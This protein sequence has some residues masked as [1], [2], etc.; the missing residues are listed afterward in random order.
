[1]SQGSRS[2]PSR[3]VMNRRSVAGVIV[4]VVIIALAALALLFFML[5]DLLVDR[6]WFE[7][8]HQLQVWDLN[9]FSRL[10]LWI[11]VSVVAFLVLTAS[12]WL[13]VRSAGEAAPH[14]T[15][16]RKS[17]RGTQTPEGFRPPPT[18]DV[19]VEVLT[20]IDEV[21]REI[22]PRVLGLVLTGVAL[23]LALLIGLSTSAEWQTL[24]LY[25]HQATEAAVGAA[26]AGP[27][28][29]TPVAALT[30]PIFGRPLTFYLFDMPFYRMAAELVGSILDSLILLTGLAY[31]VLARRSGSLPGGRLWAWHLGILVALRIAIGA[32]GFQLDKF[33]LVFSQR[34]YPLPSGVSATDA[35]VR[36]PAADVLTLLT[37]AAAI[38]VLAAIVRQRFTWALGVFGVWV[39]VAVA[40]GLLAVVNQSLF[41]NPNPLDQER[42]YISNDIKATRLAYGLDGW[43]SRPYPAINVLT[44]AAL[45]DDAET[46]ANARLWDYRPLGATLDQLQTVRQYYDFADVDIDRYPIG[47]RQRQV[48]LSAREMA[49]DKN[50]SVNNWLN[51]HF[52]YTHGYGVAMVPVNAVQPDGLPDLIIRDMPV[53][54][55]PGAPDVT[56]PR[57][58]FGERPSPWVITGAQTDE[59]DYP[60][61]GE[62]ADATT[63]WTGTTGIDIGDGIN[64]LLL[65]I[66][67]GDFVSL[68][69]SPQIQDGSQFLMRRTVGERLT[70]LA[71]FISF[72]HDPYLVVTASG[73]LVWIVDGY[74]TTDRFPLARAFDSRRIGGVT[75]A[76]SVAFNYIRNSVK[77]VV[78]AYDG[79][80]NLYVNDPHD[81]LIATWASIY[82]SLFSS[83]ADLPVELDPHL[84]YPEGMFN[85]QTGMFEAYHVTD[86]TTFYQG[87]N[88]WTVPNGAQ[89]QSQVLPSEAYYVQ[90]RLPGA[91]DTEY[92]LM[93]PMVPARRP[94]MISWIAARNDGPARG[95]VLVYQLPSDTS[96]FGPAQIEARIDQTPEISAQITL[97]DQSGSSVIRGNLIVVPVGGS[98][99]YLEPIYLQS[100]SSA[101]PQFT[102]IVV[103]TPTR[104]VWANTLE[105]ALRL[106]VADAPGPLPTPEGGPTPTPGPQ[107]TPRPGD[108]TMPADVN[109]LIAFANDHFER[110]QGAIGSGDYVTYGKEMALVQAALERLAQLTQGSPAPG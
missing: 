28:A 58:Y 26:A 15:R 44:P 23:V 66:W 106:A 71:P 104:V 48:M 39:A 41:V 99:V 32:V 1:M 68:L 107:V 82:P 46:F 65:S 6:L 92:L 73:R 67:T 63:R 61:G 60:S 35:A 56:E 21:A 8:I 83:M 95:E 70:A 81:P 7:S 54:S 87:D 2:V 97:W 36:I 94:N 101:F 69:T 11:P 62:T 31:L 9:T 93:Q 47:G 84:R 103:A 27:G 19:V 96:I 13:A 98:F 74:T 45:V 49:L 89:S 22:S 16:I 4:A 53:V 18:E 77:A 12:V 20:T 3:P 76:P 29:S 5:N 50:P 14:V 40:A 90:M 80:V 108:D 79:T 78:D 33:S 86:A 85:A 24:L 105:T 17:L 59:F 88:L 100:T 75:N 34:A 72:D 37:I 55:E 102:K 10:L 52:I 109:G 64:R 57:I 30:D 110:A 42:P 51:A 91:D 38:V 25:Q 43:T